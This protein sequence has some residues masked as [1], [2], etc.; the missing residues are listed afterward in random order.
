MISSLRMFIFSLFVLAVGVSLSLS[1]SESGSSKVKSVEDYW[2]ETGLGP[3]ALEDL[4]QDQTCASSERYFL[5]CANAVL[6]IANRFN[7]TVTTDELLAPVATALSNDTSSEKKQLE[8]WK[9]FFSEH[10]AE[11]VKFSFFN[12]WKELEQKHISKNQKSWIFIIFG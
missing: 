5:A 9:K 3:V 10:T 4:L 7:L 11:A 2:A 6:T 12:V 1:R 8:S